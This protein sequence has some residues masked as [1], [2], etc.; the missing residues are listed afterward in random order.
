MTCACGNTCICHAGRFAPPCPVPGGC[1]LSGRAPA[2]PRCAR[3]PRC[4]TAER[5]DDQLLGGPASR[6]LCE[7]CEQAARRVLDQ[8]PELYVRLRQKTLDRDVAGP[9]EYVTRSASGSQVLGNATARDL[10]EQAHWLLTTWEDEVRSIASLNYPDRTR[11]SHG[12]Q[13][14]DAAILLSRHF[15]AWLSAPTV[16]FATSRWTP[17]VDQSGVEAIGQLLDWRATVRRLPG[18]DVDG[19]RAIRRYPQPCGRCSVSA[20]THRAG[21]DLMVCQSCGDTFP[22][23]EQLPDQEAS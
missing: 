13:V 7:V 6:P 17:T 15:T 20:I 10:A 21:D 14:Q 4:Y 8:T 1:G 22:Y 23:L 19:P 5:V 2:I 12:R 9:G 16:E 11:K 3:G 18:L